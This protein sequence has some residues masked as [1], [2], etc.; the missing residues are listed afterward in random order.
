M[1]NITVKSS[2]N[3]IKLQSTP[4]EVTGG[5]FDS[6]EVWHEFVGQGGETLKTY[7]AK[8]NSTVYTGTDMNYI[9]VVG[10]AENV[11]IT[12][13]YPIFPVSQFYQMN[14]Q[15]GL[16]LNASIYYTT[17]SSPSYGQQNFTV[18]DTTTGE[19]T[20]RGANAI[21][22]LLISDEAWEILQNYLEE[23]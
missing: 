12:S 14:W 16:G 8:T 2:G 15:N 7:R 3:T 6:E 17:S 10:Y 1:D 18:I 4:E 5:Y 9:Y 22:H 23:V 20:E 13:P 11:G 19:P 21:F